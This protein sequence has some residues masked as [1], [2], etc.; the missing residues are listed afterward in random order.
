MWMS[1]GAILLL[2]WFCYAAD[3]L[4]LS[5]LSGAELDI[6]RGMMLT[7]DVLTPNAWA[8]KSTSD[9]KSYKAIIVGD[10][11]G[12]DVS[13]LDT[14]V[15]SRHTWSPAIKGNIIILGSGPQNFTSRRSGANEQA[16]CRDR[17]SRSWSQTSL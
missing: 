8:T 2:N 5:T 14:L 9:F 7:A 12:L 3:V 13:V 16:V 11:N 1:L 10:P 6:A 17:P 15:D 4:F